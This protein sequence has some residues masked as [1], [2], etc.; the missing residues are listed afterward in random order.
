MLATRE[1]EKRKRDLWDAF[2]GGAALSGYYALRLTD[3][4]GSSGGGATYA[5]TNWQPASGAQGCLLGSVFDEAVEVLA[6]KDL[7]LTPF[8]GA[9]QG[10]LVFKT[11]TVLVGSNVVDV[12]FSTGFSESNIVSQSDILFA[13]TGDM[14][15]TIVVGGSGHW[16]ILPEASFKAAGLMSDETVMTG[17]PAPD[18]PNS[19]SPA[20]AYKWF[21]AD[22]A[23]VDKY[24]GRF[25]LVVGEEVA[26][27][28]ASFKECRARGK[29]LGISAPLVFF[30][31]QDDDEN[32]AELGL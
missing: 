10:S 4:L 1:R 17:S 25:V 2:Q 28:A 16:I 8:V 22:P 12:T 32:V 9:W 7:A 14:D 6:A 13:R 15:L 29:A 30:V 3:P 31:P 26:H 20:A 18:D 24:R 5:S 11:E 23:R 27:S 21:F 19:R